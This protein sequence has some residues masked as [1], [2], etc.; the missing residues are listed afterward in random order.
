MR[1]MVQVRK[2]GNGYLTRCSTDKWNQAVLV[3]NGINIGA[4]YTKRLIEVCD[5]ACCIDV[6]YKV[7]SRA[8]GL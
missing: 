1:Y 4:P 7:I 5:E 3:Y 6:P 8:K 2:E